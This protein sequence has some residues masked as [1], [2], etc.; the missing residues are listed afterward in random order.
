MP[1]TGI[2]CYVNFLKTANAKPKSP[3]ANAGGNEK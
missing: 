1:N 3:Q 2:D